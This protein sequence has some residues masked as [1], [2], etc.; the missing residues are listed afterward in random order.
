MAIWIPILLGVG[1]LIGV[2]LGVAKAGHGLSCAEEAKKIAEE[3]R[4]R[5]EEALKRLEAKKESLQR[6]VMR[7]GERKVELYKTLIARM[8]R[9]LKKIGKSEQTIFEVKISHLG[10]DFP[11]D[12]KAL[13][14][15]LI[16]F[17][18]SLSALG[19]LRSG[20]LAAGGVYSAVGLFGTAS[21]GVAISSLSGA[22]AKSAIL[23]WLGGGALAAGGGGMLLGSVVLGGIAL[24]PAVLV[25]GFVLASKG[26][27]ELTRAKEY[28]ANVNKKIAELDML[29]DALERIKTRV[30]ELYSIGE[31]LAQRLEP[32]LCELEAGG[33][34]PKNPKCLEL[35]GYGLNLALA[36]LE[37]LKTPILVGDNN[38]LSIESARVVE[39][40]RHYAVKV[41]DPDANGGT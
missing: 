38:E 5:H 18:T 9:I 35:F 7:F 32:V 39:K 41:N 37:V 17:E 11:R 10:V 22:A 33:W 3:A 28:E 31:G 24:A 15:G 27:K 16:D 34:S 8:V 4:R 36:M 21:T 12:A 20:A 26:E 1:A 25:F 40:Y 14:L 23:A 2:G 30:N 19:A 13:E 29:C 6:L